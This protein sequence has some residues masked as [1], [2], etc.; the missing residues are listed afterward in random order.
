M[1]TSKE[2]I[3]S[4]LASHPERD[5]NWLAEKCE[6][7]KRTVDN[8]LSSPQNIPSKAVLIIEGLMRADAETQPG[9]PVEL[10]NLPV[11]CTA[12]QFDLYTRAFRHSEQEHFR[13]WITSRLDAAAD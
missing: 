10:V 6:V 7:E 13:D 11:Q 9:R 2:G 4:W 8:W 5:R 12:D 3:K 1:D